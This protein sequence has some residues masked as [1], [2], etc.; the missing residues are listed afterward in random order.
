MDL[1]HCV[2]RKVC[3]GLSGDRHAA[4]GEPVLHQAVE[5]TQR[6]HKANL[7]LITNEMMLCTWQD[8]Q[9][10]GHGLW[11]SWPAALLRTSNT[12]V[13]LVRTH[14]SGDS[15]LPNDR[16]LGKEEAPSVSET[17]TQGGRNKHY[18]RRICQRHGE[19]R[20]RVRAF[21]RTR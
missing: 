7:T 18:L 14:I 11:H 21:F 10:R 3:V 17:V 2:N 13:M 12:L 15:P 9:H 6:G 16:H 20:L 19:P 4:P 1:G 5:R 8:R